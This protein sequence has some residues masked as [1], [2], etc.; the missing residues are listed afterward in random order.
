M[1]EGRYDMPYEK[2]LAYNIIVNKLN[3]CLYLMT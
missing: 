1:Y 2:V 3:I